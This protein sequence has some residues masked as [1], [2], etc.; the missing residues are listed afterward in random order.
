MNDI[1]N[2][3]VI[4][5]L[6]GRGSNA[7]GLAV[8]N[9]EAKPDEAAEALHLE[10]IS[11]LPAVTIEPDLETVRAQQ[12]SKLAATIVRD[13]PFIT[14]YVSAH[15]LASKVS[16][17]D[18]ANLDQISQT[19]S[20]FGKGS[21]LATAAEGFH[22]GMNLEGL[23]KEY[24]EL[25][26][27]YDS[28]WWK[29]FIQT[30]GLVPVAARMG[31]GLFGGAIHAISGA[32]GE[33]AIQAGM[34]EA[35]AKRLTRDIRGGLEAN[36][37]GAHLMKSP[38]AS[39]FQAIA[40]AAQKAKPYFENGI[41]P[42]IGLDPTI[43]K[44]HIDQSKQDLKTF[45]E[46]TSDAQKS[47]TRQRSP[48]L[49]QQ[50]MEQHFQ[51]T[52]IGISG[53]R[54][55]ELYKDKEP[56]PGDGLLGDFPN[57]A[58]QLRVAR[59][60][61]GDVQVPLADWLA[62]IEPEL[63]K[64][65]H[66]DI[67]V[68][69]NNLT[70]KE[71]EA[72]KEMAMVEA[73]HGSPH[74][75][76]AFDMGKIG[77]GE[78]AQ[79]YGHGLYF[80]E[81]Q[82]VAEQYAK[83][84]V[85]WVDKDG[86]K[87]QTGNQYRVR[88]HAEK[89]QFLDWDK[90]LSATES[91]KRALTELETKHPE[92]FEALEDLLDSRDQPSIRDLTGTQLYQLLGKWA[93][94]DSLP[95][96][97]GDGSN[98]KAEASE[99]LKNLG[100][101]G[102][103]YLDQGSRN[104]EMPEQ[105]AKRREDLLSEVTKLTDK[106]I[107]SLSKEE[108]A[109]ASEI[110][111]EL[112]DIT[113]QYQDH[114][115]KQ[116]SYNYV[117]FDPSII[118]IVDRNGEAIQA[119]RTSAALDPLLL[120]MIREQETIRQEIGTHGEAFIPKRGWKLEEVEAINKANE[121]LDRLLPQTERYERLPARQL[122]AGDLQAKGMYVSYKSRIPTIAFL[123][124]PEKAV[125][126]VRH[127]AIHYL[128]QGGF[129]THAEWETLKDAANYNDWIN[130]HKIKERY[131]GKSAPEMLEEA[132][133]EEFVAWRKD[134][135]DEGAVAKIFRKIQ[136]LGDRVRDIIEKAIGTKE[137]AD[138]IFEKVESGEVGA[139]KDT[140]PL[141][142]SQA[143]LQT[144]GAEQ[145]IFAKANAIGMTVPQYQR[146]QKLIEKRN[147][148]DMEAQFKRAQA[149]VKQRQTAEWK[150]NYARIEPEARA[151]V[152]ARPDIMAGRFFIEGKVGDQELQPKPRLNTNMLT[153]EQQ[154]AL[155]RSWQ[156][157]KGIS[158]DDAANLFGYLNGQVLIAKLTELD[159]ARAGKRWNEYVDSEVKREANARMERQFGD[160]SK[161]ILDE[162][163]EHVL[164]I[165]Q[166]DLLHEEMVALGTKAGADTK[167]FTK[168]M[169]KG[170][171]SENFAKLPAAGI[172]TDRFLKDAGKAGREAELNLLKGDEAE[173]FRQKGR[174]YLNV[175]LAR[176]AK[177]FE[178]EQ[179]RFEKKAKRFSA[180]QVN[181]VDQAYT[182][183]IQA[184]L[185]QAGKL[186]KR[187]E[188]EI[189]ESLSHHGYDSF[190][191][192]VR[193]KYSEG[194]DIAVAD[195][196]Q[197]GK[198]K[199]LQ[200]MNVQEFRDFKEAI[201]SLAHV[202]REEK[203][204]EIAGKKL[205]LE[206]LRS[207]VLENIRELPPTNNKSKWRFLWKADAELVKVEEVVKD[208]DLRQPGGP[209]FNALI[210]PLAEAKSKEYGMLDKLS[211]ELSEI[212]GFNAEWRKT[213]HDTIP[214]DFLMD[215]FTSSPFDMSRSM[216]V[217]IMLNF[218]NKSNIEKFTKGYAG[219]KAPE[220]E[221]KL[222]DMFDKH[223]TKEDWQFVQKIWDLFETWRGES[224]AMYRRISGVPPKWIEV[225][226]VSTRH[227]D[228]RGGYF[229]IIYDRLR[230][231]QNIIEEKSRTS[232][233]T[234]DVD[235][236]RATTGAGYAKAR[237]GYVDYVSFE[238][239]VEQ[240]AGRMQQM[241]HDISHREAVINAGKLVYD[242]GIRAAIRK[243][244]GIE[245]EKQLHP[246]LKDIANH[247]N[248]DELATAETNSW[249][250]RFRFNLVTHALGLN[251]RV[252]LS[253]NPGLFNPRNAA[254]FWLNRKDNVALAEA[255]SKEIPHVMRSIDRDFREKLE[256]TMRDKGWSDVQSTAFRWSFYPIVALERELRMVAFSREFK[257]ALQQGMNE[258]DAGARADSLI[259]ERQGTAG[260]MDLPAIMRSNEAMKMATMFYGFFNTMYNWQRQ[261]PGQVRRAEY[262]DAMKTVYGSIL[263]PSAFTAVLF[264]PGGKDD[265]WFKVISKAILTQPL[266]TVP[267][268]RE[269][270]TMFAEGFP[271]R[272]PWESL[273]NAVKSGASD[274]RRYR[275]GKAIEKPITHTANIIGLTAGLPLG[276]IG[277]SAQFGYD[278]ATNK[279][280]PKN[281]LQWMR[282][283]ITGEAVPKR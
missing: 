186:V 254:D 38:L 173:A 122:N 142:P 144:E 157:L 147:A 181:G 271:P 210:R 32:T 278:V 12:K 99:F 86:N 198:A 15:P 119:V 199:P 24:S 211:K 7:A 179:E 205:E 116:Q 140:T 240:I 255:H 41:E 40:K 189:V 216:M 230:S 220:L 102:I 46:L 160:L 143:K 231:N 33:A 5:S 222:W 280:K 251:L 227:G 272:T 182:D 84:G 39:E 245:Y 166:M 178:K 68:R 8:A 213:L 56:A 6:M 65:L 132:I 156:S 74:Q 128:R 130:K 209:L 187:T 93:S 273:M 196:L 233:G 104:I 184:L 226:P 127:E 221:A 243:H 22:H 131:E 64:E 170:W 55:A 215:P 281:I 98:L 250:R 263:L 11:G 77:T 117:I 20:K 232:G 1:P 88:I 246:W 252:I 203:L 45:D 42:P 37:S 163:Y 202:G 138:A 242:K 207:D 229:P 224:D 106:G 260:S 191:S 36:L 90:D 58:E 259:R 256:Q 247:F 123:A 165:T 168:E 87:L 67:R 282:G 70:L 201:D 59:E 25:L 219:K 277:R 225:S 52:K 94:E 244:Y 72:V 19:A 97:K 101:P 239:S 62:R 151:S 26:H 177:K 192:F 96:V 133:A 129:F 265:S 204:I 159:A 141:D 2:Q 23:A 114:R 223:A 118:E 121:E 162:A 50:F 262:A 267:F 95:G 217:N 21:I 161:N 208:L 16:N 124:N 194:Y 47:T 135:V 49:F 18:Y 76:D 185:A 78:G 167:P 218:G 89:E 120:R 35:E 9:I 172:K 57:I 276:Q 158:P 214:N 200:E 234:F 60:T 30:A 28:P 54:L 257:R 34:N 66:D 107:D 53:E 80:A 164:G 188:A 171:V 51:D 236:F 206:Q 264:S 48:E 31:M 237:S 261:I 79:A 82:K 279:Q 105:L 238:N 145:A 154:M 275:E 175:E 152:E 69:P 266:T 183:F 125:G 100:I 109:R 137:A 274:V 150:E 180:R 44:F 3:I 91:G 113:S 108:M 126:A 253:P 4:D 212:K 153:T 85:Q 29:T 111:K 283:I 17:D 61:G 258:A 110:D 43:D 71:Q 169:I 81:N 268:L 112:I 27:M 270:V 193:E 190:T 155:P 269:G 235:Y 197:E 92:L 115:A 241:V 10:R 149:A 139:R 148:E 73:Y 146:Y 63:A 14:D 103:K 136:E 75:F 13:N 176:E 249:L 195:Y 134:P 228:F 248:V 83:M 174:Q